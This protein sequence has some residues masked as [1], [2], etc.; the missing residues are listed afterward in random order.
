[1]SDLTGSFENSNTRP[2]SLEGHPTT[3]LDRSNRNVRKGRRAS[4]LGQILANNLIVSRRGPIALLRLSRPAKRN[5]LDAATIAGIEEFFSDPP[6]GT[7][8]IIVYGEGKHFSAG[9]DLSALME[10]NVEASLRFSRAFHRAFEKIENSEVPVIAVLQ[11]AVIGGGL[12]LAAAAH[13]RIAERGAYYGLP[14]NALGIFV[15]GGGAIRIPRLIGTSR[16]V[17]MMLTGRTYSAEEGLHLGLSQYLVDDGQGIAK[18][19][20]LAEKIAGNAPL[21]NFA[22]LQALPRI[23]RAEPD[24]AFLTESLM[25]ALTIVDD[26]AKARLEAFFRKRA[27]KAALSTGGDEP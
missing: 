7:R 20:E 19:L 4:S 23:A 17:D 25:A 2:L 14:E 12:E 10:A 24:N 6:D 21:S 18:G 15:G 22:V 16:M 26:E 9:A 11:G 3:A 13:I 8:A 27:A 5:A 1:M